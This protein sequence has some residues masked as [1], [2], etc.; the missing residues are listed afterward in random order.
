MKCHSQLR[1]MH[2]ISDI[3]I[4][5]T[6]NQ[7]GRP[8]AFFSRTLSPAERCHSSVEKEAYAVVESVPKWRHYLAARHFTLVTDQRSVSYM[9][10]KTHKSKIKNDKLLRWRTELSPYRFDIVY[11]P[12]KKNIPA[13]TLSRT[14]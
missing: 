3:A 7:C 12:G 1:L 9:F 6:L 4:A 5:A 11:R 10:S 14:H 2:R 8:V 13:D